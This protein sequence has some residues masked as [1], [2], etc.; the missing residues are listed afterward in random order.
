MARLCKSQQN[1]PRLRT[2]LLV[3]S[4]VVEVGEAWISLN[5]YVVTESCAW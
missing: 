1:I 5:D 4:L 3:S 2:Y